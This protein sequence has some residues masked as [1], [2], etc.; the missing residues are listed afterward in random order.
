[1]GNIVIIGSSGHAKVVIDIVELDGRYNIIGLLD[2]YREPKSKVCNYSILGSEDDLIDLVEN[3]NVIGGIIAIGDNNV[4]SRIVAELSA[5]I[6]EF[7]FVTAIHPRAVVAADVVIGAGT[8]V[9]A[10]AVVNPG[11]QIGAHS[12]LNTNSSLDHDSTLGACSSLAPG[13]ATG[14][15][16]NIG[17]NSAICIGAKISHKVNVGSNCVVGAGAVVFCDVPNN[18]VFYGAPARFVR[19]H[20]TGDSYL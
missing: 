13:V 14:G 8:V 7:E 9:M 16:V 12:V 20:S 15:G 1:M 18:Q 4:R 5:V 10:G 19:N 11:C 17:T 3:Q 6:P 2:R